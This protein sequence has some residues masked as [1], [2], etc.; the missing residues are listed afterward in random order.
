MPPQDPDFE[1]RVRE[2]L[3]RQA[4]MTLLGVTLTHIAPGEVHLS[5][6]VRDEL[7]QQHGSVHAGV[8]ASV[9]DSAAGYAAFT[10][11]PAGSGVVSVEFKV[12]L[13]EPAF[14]ERIEARARVVR[15]G[16][17]L[18]SVAAEAWVVE[19]GAERLAATFSGTMMC[20]VGRGVTG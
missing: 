6:P 4:Y 1:S 2:S 16:R 12:N 15:A 11:M 7:R 17:T 5:F 13:L 20:L 3:A 10:R 14:G 8:L 18:S 9:M 19:A